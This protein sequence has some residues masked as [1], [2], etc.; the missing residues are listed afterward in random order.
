MNKKQIDQLIQQF[1][2]NP[3]AAK[4][5]IQA[6]QDHLIHFVEHD[7][8]VDDR[9]FSERYRS[10]QVDEMLKLI[11]LMDEDGNYGWQ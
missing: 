7:K 9:T 2:V 11:G 6:N 8:D 5:V 1:E 10:H 4:G 3:A